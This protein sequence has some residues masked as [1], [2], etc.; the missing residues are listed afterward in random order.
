MTRWRIRYEHFLV[1]LS[2]ER[3]PDNPHFNRYLQCTKSQLAFIQ[4]T[5]C[6]LPMSRQ[7]IKSLPLNNSIIVPAEGQSGCL[8]LIWGD[9][10]EIDLCEKNKN[11]IAVQVTEKVSR[12]KWKF[13]GIYGDPERSQNPKIWEN[14]ETHLQED[15][16]AVCLVGDFNS[17]AAGSEKWGGKHLHEHP[18]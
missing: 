2:G 13:V 11:L 10:V 15:D 16:E 5:R 3:G 7:R 9:E 4:E 8:W 17:I 1:E 14:I 12:K 6:G 18:K